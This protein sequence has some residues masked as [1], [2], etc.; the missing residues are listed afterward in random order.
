MIAFYF[1]VIYF[2]ALIYF[3]FIHDDGF[4]KRIKSKIKNNRLEMEKRIAEIK[5]E[6]DVFCAS[7]QNLMEV[8]NSNV[9]YEACEELGN[10][11]MS[12][13]E[14]VP[15]LLCGQYLKDKSFLNN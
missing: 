2:S 5:K 6:G 7:I 10:K 13:K 12:K 4:D 15:K 3:C 8:E 11:E 14:V 9:I 1:L